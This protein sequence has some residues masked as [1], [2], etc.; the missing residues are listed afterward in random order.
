MQKKT[1]ISRI[2]SACLASVIFACPISSGANEITLCE[3]NQDSILS[4]EGKLDAEGAGILVNLWMYKDG[5]LVLVKQSETAENGKYSLTADMAAFTSGGQYTVKTIAQIE[6]ADSRLFEFYSQGELEGIYLDIFNHKTDADYIADKLSDEYKNRIVFTNKLYKPLIDDGKS[7]NVANFLKSELDK[8][9]VFS[10]DEFIEILNYAAAVKTIEHSD[11]AEKIAEYFVSD[12]REER[13]AKHSLLRLGGSKVLALFEENAEND[14]LQSGDEASEKKKERYMAFAEKMLSLNQAYSDSSDFVSGVEDALVITDIKRCRGNES[15]LNMITDYAEQTEIFDL[16][17][18]NSEDNDKDAVIRKVA[19]KFE[20]NE[21]ETVY[22]LQSLLDTKKAVEKPKSSSGRGSGSGSGAIAIIPPTDFDEAEL[23]KPEVADF[24]DMGDY[25]WA[26][27]SVDR[28]T[29]LGMLN[30]YTKDSFG[31]GDYVTRAQFSK[32]MCMVFGIDTVAG[33]TAFTDVPADAWYADYVGSLYNAGYVKGISST[34]FGSD[35]FISRQDA[36]A[37]VY[38]ILKDKGLVSEE[39]SEAEFKDWEEVSDY[40]KPALAA[41][42]AKKL[43]QGNDGNIM[44]LS[45]MTRAEAAV[46]MHRIYE[47]VK[48]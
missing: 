16:T 22:Q 23:Q 35:E 31:P 14:A 1:K 34:F 39:I 11:N 42:F 28:L 37:I 43:V 7:K 6:E 32:M 26:Q 41:L 24:K 25:Q 2:L 17:K 38:R 33:D 9:D 44:P 45:N 8:C 3:V 47:E 4:L 29:G 15:V 19:S 21:I 40:A 48:Q 5:K 10:V 13:E 18:F 46:T 36:F 27:E 30:G 20:K 12:S